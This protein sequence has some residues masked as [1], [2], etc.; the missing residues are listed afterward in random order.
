MAVCQAKV[1]C[2]NKYECRKLFFLNVVSQY[3]GMEL[4]PILLPISYSERSRGYIHK[5]RLL[6]T[7]RLPN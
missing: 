6:V 2:Q 5:L 7:L 3:E 1:T 4:R